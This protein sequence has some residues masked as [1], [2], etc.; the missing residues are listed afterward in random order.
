MWNYICFTLDQGNYFLFTGH[1]LH[2]WKLGRVVA[3]N[4]LPDYKEAWGSFQTN[5]G[6]MC[7]KH[8]LNIRMNQTCLRVL[9]LHVVI[10]LVK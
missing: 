5:A 2:Q 9:M 7:T 8:D 1:E 6:V 10:E 4:H 3:I